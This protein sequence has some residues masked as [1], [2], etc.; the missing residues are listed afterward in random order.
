LSDSRTPARCWLRMYEISGRTGLRSL[1]W[2]L[3]GP[4]RTKERHAPGRVSRPLAEHLV[5]SELVISTLDVHTVSLGTGWKILEMRMGTKTPVAV[6]TF[7]QLCS[8]E[9]GWF[10]IVHRSKAPRRYC[11][12]LL[13]IGLLVH[14]ADRLDRTF[15]VKC[16]WMRK[17]AAHAMRKHV[18]RSISPLECSTS[19]WGILD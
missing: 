13:E 7:S 15:A 16:G 4:D 3:Y 5:Q 14:S 6:M 8:T 9:P 2:L 18:N 11:R 19:I 10:N 17:P 12:N 1:T